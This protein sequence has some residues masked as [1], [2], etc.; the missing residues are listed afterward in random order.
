MSTHII[1]G[2]IPLNLVPVPA[3]SVQVSPLVPG[4]E[5][6]EA[7]QPG[8]CDGLVMRAPPNTL[9]RRHEM[10]LALRA[11]R[12][13]AEFAILAAKD[14]GGTRLG[15][16]LAAFGLEVT[17]QPRHHHRICSGTRPDALPGI[18]QAI[19][20]GAPRHV[21]ELNLWSQPG[22]FSWDRFDVGSAVLIEVLPALAG[23]V[24][25]FGCGYGLLSL[26]A[27]RSAAVTS[28][29][30]FD[31]DRRA[32]AAARRNIMD[33]RFSATWV[34]LAARGAGVANLDAILMNPPF[35]NAGVEDQALG[36]ALIARASEA[37]RPGG[38]LWLTANR[39]LPYEAVLRTRFRTV[40]LVAQE[41]G[42]K[43]YQAIK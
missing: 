38:V 17:D 30:A 9:E 32:I 24:G 1:Y 26:A 31:L 19:A 7:L 13:G 36:Q 28:V 41:S 10:A 14:K 43:V 15:K 23:E 2:D 25:D 8:S 11:L 42:F 18:E 21:P 27:L 3:G 29:H 39:H 20:D 6:L 37:L 5:S 34:D 12:P 33:P 35:H 16:E 22:L 4:A 40:R